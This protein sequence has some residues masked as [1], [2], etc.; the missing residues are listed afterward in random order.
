MKHKPLHNVAIV[1][2]YTALGLLLCSCGQ[3]VYEAVGKPSTVARAL[4]ATGP[5]ANGTQILF[6]DLHVHTTYSMDAF[7]KSLSFFGGDGAH[8]PA[9]ACDFARYC[10]RLDFWSINDHAEF[11]SPARWQNTRD[12]IRQCN[13]VSGSAN[14]PDMVSFLGWEW[15]QIGPSPDNHYGHK[16]VVLRDL[17]D[18]KLPARPISS[19][20]GSNQFNVGMP[21]WDVLKDR[22]LRPFYDPANRAEHWQYLKYTLQSFGT[23]ACDPA[24]N[25]TK[26]PVD[27]HESAGT[28]ADLFARLNEW[29]SE[30]I[31]IPHGNA[32][33]LY[34]PPGSNWEKQLHGD[35]AGGDRQN[36]I[37]VFSGHGNSEEY[38]SWRGVAYDVAGKA[39]CPPPADAYIPCCWQA[40]E[41]IR[42]QCGDPESAQCETQVEQA[43]MN[44]V[45]AGASGHLTVKGI[46][47]DDWQNCG[48]CPGCFLPAFSLRPGTSA[49]A[50][51]ATGEFSQQQA[52]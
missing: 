10:S 43:K 46:T 11:L 9:D 33:G 24:V 31:V 5:Q 29:R 36:L 51:L 26:L 6:G 35:S 8:P 22:L 3:D 13:A 25:S 52:K 50:A 39:Y 19:S 44:H 23:K 28:P 14:N 12:L 16:N 20:D 32:W 41:I 18:A 7:E 40:G 42:R 27:C 30:Y 34:T 47:Q 4:T 1:V 21:Y 48:Q 45:A 37:E 49:Q 38:R 15:T 2:A 17:A